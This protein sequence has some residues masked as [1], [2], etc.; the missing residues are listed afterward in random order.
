M[1]GLFSF[2]EI[3][4]D[5]P[6]SFGWFHFLWVA[7]VIAVTT[8][9]IIKFRDCSDKVYRRI[10]LIAWIIMLVFEIYKQ[11][12]FTFDWNGTEVVGDYQWY[13][14]PF[15]LCSTPL[16][17]LPFVAFMKEGKVRDYFSSFISTFALFGGLVVF[18][19]PNDVFID[20]LGINIQTMVHHGLQI[21]TGIFFAVHARRRLN[22]KY[23]LKSIP[24]FVG[25]MIVAIVM[26]EAIWP[27]ILA[28]NPSDS[29][30]MFYVSSHYAN[31]LPILSMVYNAVPWIAFVFIY[32]V[33][34]VIASLAVY[35]AIFGCI[36]LANFI[37]KKELFKKKN[38]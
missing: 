26:N 11:I 3:P 21:V 32:I 38:A 25:L 33:G 20:T 6:P 14:F 28:N 18:V 35:Y 34:F 23:F 36:K 29:F 16:Y 9:L 1:E 4:M 8:F 12:V 30:S 2:L 24:V 5:T 7:I 15:Q 10:A 27:S 19:Y 31:H 17:I 37:S 13:S 22:I